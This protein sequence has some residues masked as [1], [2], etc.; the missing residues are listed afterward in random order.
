[1]R[2]ELLTQHPHDRGEFTASEWNQFLM[3]WRDSGVEDWLEFG[4]GSPTWRD[5][6]VYFFTNTV[7]SLQ[8]QPLHR[9]AS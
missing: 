8:T 7:A 6:P 1:M 4:G 9:G 5:V 3:D 2:G